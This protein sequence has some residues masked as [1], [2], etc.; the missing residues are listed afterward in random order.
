M[1]ERGEVV[2]GGYIRAMTTCRACCSAMSRS[3]FNCASASRHF[4]ICSR[5]RCCSCKNLTRSVFSFCSNNCCVFNSSC[6]S[7]SLISRHSNNCFLRAASW[8]IPFLVRVGESPVVLVLVICP[9]EVWS[10]LE[11]NDG[12]WA[13]NS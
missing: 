13:S 12:P 9:F 7:L 10:V 1:Y 4:L 8:S 5:F 3:I 2:L 11:W 6:N